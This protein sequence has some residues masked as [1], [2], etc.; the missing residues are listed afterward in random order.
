MEE[1]LIKYNEKYDRWCRS[2]GKIYRQTKT[3]KFIEC[4]QKITKWGYMIINFYKKKSVYSHRLIWETLKGPINVGY[5]IDHIN[6]IKTDNRIEN[7]RCVTHAENMNNPLTI[8]RLSKSTIGNTRT[9]N[10]P[11]SNSLFGKKYYEHYGY[12]KF[13]N[14]KQYE[15]ER[16][17]Y[18]R[19]GKCRWEK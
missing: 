3:G 17:W 7:L 18:L 13:E 4:K 16:Q 19:N 8:K 10:K 6:T 9:R 2:D 15:K 5:E 14:K 1:M 11:R 12:C